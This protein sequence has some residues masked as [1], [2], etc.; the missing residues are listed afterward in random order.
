MKHWKRLLALTLSLLLLTG[1]GG[2]DVR[3]AGRQ[4]RPSERYSEAV[5][6]DAMDVVEDH[7]KK[8]FD[9]CTLHTIVYD[10]EAT[11]EKAAREEEKYGKDT[12]ILRTDFWVD[13][14]GG[15]AALNPGQTYRNYEWTLTRTM[16][17]WKL[18]DQGYA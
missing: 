17:G 10:E 3:S 13:E 12:I 4:I 7:F 1:C 9:G 8:N 6:A 18:Q 2:G 11:G 16:F 5:I 14:Q 15:P